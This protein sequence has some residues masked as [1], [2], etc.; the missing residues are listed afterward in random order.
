MKVRNKLSLQF[1]FLF[2]VLLTGVLAGIYLYVQHN[3]TNTFYDRLAERAVTVAQFY[4]AED[5]VSKEKFSKISEKF[6]QSL[7]KENIRIYDDQFRPRFV[8]ES[9]VN[10]NEKILQQIT[11]KKK[12]DFRV[13]ERQVVGIDYVDNS[14]NYIIV[15]S[16]SDE[17]GRHYLH[18]LRIIMVV[19]FLFSLLITFFAGLLFSRLA[20]QPIKHITGDLERIRASSLDLRLPVVNKKPD[21]IDNLSLTINQVLEHLQQSFDNQSA[22]ISNASHELRTPI[23]TILGEAEITMMSERSPK[24]YEAALSNIIKEAERLSY[25]INSLLDLIQTNVENRSME[26]IS[27]SELFWDIKDELE[28]R[29]PESCVNIDFNLSEELP[30]NTI[31]GNRQLLLIA[32]SNIIKNAIKFSDQQPVQ[33]HV[34]SDRKGLHI[35]IKDQGIGISE[36]DMDKIFQP[37]F[38]SQNAMTYPGSGIGLAL[39]QNIIKLHNGTMKVKSQLK[40]GTEF[41]ITFPL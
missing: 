7:P 28:F 22:F 10:W 11:E 21:E 20:L 4:L 5:N 18:S 40:Q 9:G 23:T 27:M 29:N 16:A 41:Q 15:V 8:P 33:C 6:P 3:R 19:F 36:K 35:K 37:F 26:S 25:I 13:N 14:G 2:A 17:L 32:I 1:T 39:T 24:E 38:R 34:Y 31:L 12:L 30:K